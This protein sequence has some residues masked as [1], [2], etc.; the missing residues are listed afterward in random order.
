MKRNTACSFDP[1]LNI[2]ATFV[3]NVLV[4]IFEALVLDSPP[5]MLR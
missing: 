1:M 3:S 2:E 5:P 4:S